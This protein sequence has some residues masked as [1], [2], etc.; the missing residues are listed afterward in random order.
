MN[1]GLKWSLIGCGGGIV[2]LVA[3]LAIG[4]VLMGRAV[5]HERDDLVAR[6]KSQGYREID[7]K[8]TDKVDVTELEITEPIHGKAVLNADKVTVRA[9]ADSD[10]AITAIDCSVDSK[11]NGNLFFHIGQLR[12]GPNGTV[13]G[14]LEV[15]CLRVVVEGYIQGQIKGHHTHLE[16]ANRKRALLPEQPTMQEKTTNAPAIEANPADTQQPAQP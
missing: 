3:V 1:S 12:I 2:V 14:D 15:D 11:V 8:P 9:D 13:M 4:Y 10:L 6:Y 16:D 7:G 5:G